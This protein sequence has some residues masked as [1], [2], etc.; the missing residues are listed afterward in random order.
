MLVW[1][2]CTDFSIN[3]GDAHA[4]VLGAGSS[5]HKRECLLFY[6]GSSSRLDLEPYMIA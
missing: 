3:P 4:A 2:T 5:E 6:N 1:S